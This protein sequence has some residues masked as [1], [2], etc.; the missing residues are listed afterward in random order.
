MTYLGRDWACKMACSLTRVVAESNWL[1]LSVMHCDTY[2][3]YMHVHSILVVSFTSVYSRGNT[4]A[5]LCRY[6]EVQHMRSV[7]VH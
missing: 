5:H 1:I 7:I 2:G 4:Q 3:V 6:V